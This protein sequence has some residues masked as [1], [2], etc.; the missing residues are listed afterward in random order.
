MT[1]KFLTLW[2]RKLFRK[3]KKNPLKSILV[4]IVAPILMYFIATLIYDFSAIATAGY[5]ILCIYAFHN[6]IDD[7]TKLITWGAGY[8]MGAVA[9]SLIFNKLIPT[10]SR[11]DWTS[12]FAGFVLIY[13]IIALWSKSR[14]IRKIKKR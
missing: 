6:I 2:R 14:K 12:V 8:I 11:N 5:I 3:I 13:I 7:P 10:L 1:P 9:I 4:I